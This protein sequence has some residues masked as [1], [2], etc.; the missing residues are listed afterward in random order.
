MKKLRSVLVLVL[1]MSS[2]PE[3]LPWAK[4]PGKQFLVYFGTY[5]RNPSRG[6]YVSRFDAGTG[7]V[8]PP[9]LA[10]ETA[11]PSFLAVHPNRRYLYAVGE[12]DSFNGQK[13]GAVSAFAIDRKSGKLTFLNQVSSRGAGPCYVTVDATSRSALVAN[14]GGGSVAALPIGADGRLGEASAFVQHSGT[15][16]DP[17]R[18]GG[19]HGHSIDLA[20]D[21]RFAVAADLGLD[22]LMVYR[23]DPARGTLEPNDPPFASVAPRSGPRHFAFHPSGRFGYAINEIAS[24]VTAFGYD[25]RRGTLTQLQTLTT[26]PKDFQG[27]NSTAEIAV[28]PSGKFLYG[29]NRGHDSIAVWA[30]DRSKGTLTPVEHA[31][32]L[33]KTPRNF[34]IDPTGRYLFAANQGSGTV[35]VFSIDPKTGRLKQAGSTLEVPLPVCV[36]FVALD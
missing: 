26:L 10:A 9:E 6:I 32:T 20:R 14:Y 17:R 35:A 11:N 18:Q 1:L 34:A 25:A 13:S 24:T 21:N 33:G 16:A 28:H 22:K 5:T 4:K 23:F 27:N 19:P 36:K 8:T 15:V 12:M 29:S 7:S 3:I 2:A 30:I 31:P